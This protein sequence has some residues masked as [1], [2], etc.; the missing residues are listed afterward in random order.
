MQEMSR[1]RSQAPQFDRLLRDLERAKDAWSK[2][3]HDLS[4][5]LLKMVGSI[6]MSEATVR[7]PNS[8]RPE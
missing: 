5:R 6:A 1:E 3:D 8:P 2:G 7:G 4:E